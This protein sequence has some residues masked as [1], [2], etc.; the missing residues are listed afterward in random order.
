MYRGLIINADGRVMY[1]LDEL[2]S[3]EIEDILCQ[4][5]DYKIEYEEA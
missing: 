3:R 2:T 5:K 1:R 4:H